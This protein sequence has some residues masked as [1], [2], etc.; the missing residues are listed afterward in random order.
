MIRLL[1]PIPEPAP[2]SLEVKG[3]RHHYLTRVLRLTVDDALEVFDGAGRAFSAKV[4]SVEAERATLTLGA[5]LASSAAPRIAIVQGLP[6]GDKLELVIQKGT[7]LGAW[8]FAP[9]ITD[10]AVV[11]LDP[12]RAADRVQR[13]QKIAEEA[14]RQCG[15]ADVP[16]VWPVLPLLEAVASFPHAQVLVLDEEERALRLSEAVRPDEAPRVLVIGPEGGLSRDEVQALKARGATSVTLGPRVLR[17]ETASLAA[18]AVL[19][20]L[21]GELG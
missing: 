17:T 19:A 12:K 6:K 14:A 18:L 13:W 2:E 15:R 4:R 10:R 7:E 11:K 3:E 9:A 5:P 21:A 8:A 1:L 16:R 20:H